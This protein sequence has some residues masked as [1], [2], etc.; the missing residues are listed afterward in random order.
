MENFVRKFSMNMSSSVFLTV[1]KDTI[2][3]SKMKV[4][5]SY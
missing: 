3:V 1:I 2:I 5:F 4:E